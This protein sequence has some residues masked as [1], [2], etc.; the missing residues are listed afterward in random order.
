MDYKHFE[1]LERIAQEYEEA[2][3]REYN[4]YMAKSEYE[5]HLKWQILE[6]LDLIK[7][8]CYELQKHI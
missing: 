7:N 8:T 1:E 2:R 5:E 3:I 4:D 6:I